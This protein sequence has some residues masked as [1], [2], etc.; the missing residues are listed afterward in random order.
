[1][2][3]NKGGKGDLVFREGLQQFLRIETDHVVAHD[4]RT[5]PGIHK[6]IIERVNV[7][8]GHDKKIAVVMAEEMVVDHDKILGE[9]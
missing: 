5:N 1:V 6:R 9:E 2:C 3:W 8:A 4:R 7:A